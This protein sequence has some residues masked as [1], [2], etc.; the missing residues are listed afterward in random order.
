[1]RVVVVAHRPQLQRRNRQ[2]LTNTPITTTPRAR[3]RPARP[4]PDHRT[5]CA[6][7][8]MLLVDVDGIRCGEPVG[9]WRC[10]WQVTGSRGRIGG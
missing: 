7:V 9:R 3:A 2:H 5:H 10:C 1:R 4:A 6:N 8:P